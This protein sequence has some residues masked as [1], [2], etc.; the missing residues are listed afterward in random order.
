MPIRIGG[1]ASQIKSRGL[2]RS[3][4][5]KVPSKSLNF[6]FLLG[7]DTL[8][9]SSCGGSDP[10][11]WGLKPT[12]LNTKLHPIEWAVSRPD[13]PSRSGAIH[14]TFAPTHAHSRPIPLPPRV[15]SSARGESHAAAVPSCTFNTGSQLIMP[16][17]Q[18]YDH[19]VMTLVAVRFGLG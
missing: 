8:S 4:L 19:D 17:R 18:R 9:R 13:R 1:V 14:E 15:V 6:R 10:K 7:F 3:K 2:S 5:H 11:L 16:Q 12:Q